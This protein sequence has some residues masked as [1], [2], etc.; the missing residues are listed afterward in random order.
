MKK[1]VLFHLILHFQPFKTALCHSLRNHS[2]Q[3]QA[4][5][6][7]NIF[8]RLDCLPF[9]G[10]SWCTIVHDLFSCFLRF[11][12]DH[13]VLLHAT[14]EIFITTRA[15][16]VLITL[17]AST[18]MI[19]TPTAFLVT[20]KTTPVRPRYKLRGI[21]CSERGGKENKTTSKKK[22]K[23]TKMRTKKITHSKNKNSFYVWTPHPP[24]PLLNNKNKTD[25]AFLAPVPRLPSRL[26]PNRYH[27][28]Q[29]NELTC[30]ESLLQAASSHKRHKRHKATNSAPT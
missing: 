15:V 20:S 17:M 5:H 22:I 27:S 19:S 29:S 25:D 16:H 3:I 10:K 1:Y 21:P 2:R 18:L 6:F 23:K 12:L 8:L 13:I 30:L 14:Y 26:K 11:L 28:P 9:L 7:L 4:A 24:A